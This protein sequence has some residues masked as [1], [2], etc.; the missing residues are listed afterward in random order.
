[1]EDE[2]VGVGWRQWWCPEAGG[3]RVLEGMGRQWRAAV[4]VAGG[5][6]R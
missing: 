1:L 6:G 4:V 5:R 3:D 2:E